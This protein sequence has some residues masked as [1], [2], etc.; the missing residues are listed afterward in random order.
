MGQIHRAL[1]ILVWGLFT[2]GVLAACQTTGNTPTPTAPVLARRL[3]TAAPTHTPDD[4]ERVATQQAL[5]LTPTHAP[6]T[7]TP[8]PTPYVGVFIG[9]AELD[10]DIFGVNPLN[11]VIL[12]TRIF[13]PNITVVCA[14]ERADAIFGRTWQQ[15]TQAFHQ[16]GCP[17]QESYGYDGFIQVFE[18]GAMYHNPNT[19]EVWAIA[20]GTRIDNGRYWYVDRP[21]AMSAEGLTAPQGLLVPGGVF[22]AVWVSNPELRRALGY[23]ITRRQDISVGIQRY[24]GGTLFLDATVGQIFALL[25]N[26]SALGAYNMD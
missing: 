7:L 9:E 13:M 6:P 3:A 19:D 15:D 5:Q 18:D 17:I 21:P 23:A 24:E 10:T 12:P 25:V 1:S 20:P 22:G 8:T 26:G 14:I 16:L 4:S 11:I 2:V